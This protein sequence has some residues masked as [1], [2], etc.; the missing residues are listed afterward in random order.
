MRC[1]KITSY[2]I[3][4][5]R[6]TSRQIALWGGAIACATLALPMATPAPAYAATELAYTDTNF[7]GAKLGKVFVNPSAFSYNNAII[8]YG[9]GWSHWTESGAGTAVSSDWTGEYIG[10]PG[11]SSQQSIVDP[12]TITWK[13]AGYT[14]SGQSVGIR[15]TIRSIWVSSYDPEDEKHW[16]GTNA[17]WDGVLFWWTGDGLPYFVSCTT[18]KSLD[19]LIEVIDANGNRMDMP[20][21]WS[22]LDLD[23]NDAGL[24]DTPESP[25]YSGGYCNKAFGD[26]TNHIYAEGVVIDSGVTHTYLT[27]PTFINQQVINDSGALWF[28]GTRESKSDGIQDRQAGFALYAPHG[29]ID[30]DWRG[31]DC[32][33]GMFGG[34]YGGAIPEFDKPVKST[35]NDIVYEGD[36]VTYNIDQMLPVVPD[37][38][39]AHSIT[40]TDT[41]NSAL[42]PTD[43]RVYK[44]STDVT[45]NWNISI[46]GQSVTATAKNTGHSSSTAAQGQHRFVVTAKVKTGVN[47]SALT[48]SGDYYII[49]NKA[50]VTLKPTST[51]TLTQETNTVN[52][53]IKGSAISI[54]KRADAFEY[55]PDGTITY[56]L[57]VSNIEPSSRAYNVRVADNSLPA[58]FKIHSVNISSPSSVA[59]HQ[60]LGSGFNATIPAIEYGKPVTITVKV[61]ANNDANGKIFLNTASST[62][63]NPKPGA[64]QTV[65]DSDHVWINRAKL[66]LSKTPDNREVHVGETVKYTVHLRN[67]NKGTVGRN[68]ELADELPDTMKLNKSSIKIS[69]IP[70]KVSVPVDGNHK[71]ETYQDF[72]NPYV[73]NTDATNGFSISFPL[74]DDTPDVVVEYTAEAL[75][76]GNGMTVYNRATANGDNIETPPP[77][78]EEKVFINSP[79]VD[80]DKAADAFEYSPGEIITYTV[81]VR[82]AVEGA[83]AKQVV[84]RDDLPSTVSLI[85][86]SVEVFSPT[87]A[88]PVVECRPPHNITKTEGVQ[89]EPARVATK[90]NIIQITVP[91]L[92]SGE[93][94]TV[95]YKARANDDSAGKRPVNTATVAFANPHPD[96]AIDYPKRALDD[97]WIN[98]AR[99]K[100]T[101]CADK[102]EY[103]IGETAHFTIGLHNAVSAQGTIAKNV[104]LTDTQ[105]PDD[106]KIDMDSI[107]VSGIPSPIH[108]P[109]DG[110]G[111]PQDETRD[112]KWELV[113]NEGGNGF[114]LTI[115][116]FPDNATATITYDA[117]AVKEINGLDG[118]NSASVEDDN[119]NDPGDE[120]KTH[121]WVNDAMLKLVKS[122]D[123]FEHKVGDT[124]EY[125][126]SLSNAAA[127]TI[128]KNVIIEDISLP[129]G[130]RLIENSVKVSG[131][132]EKV[133]Y[134]VAANENATEH[135]TEVRDNPV[136]VA[137]KGNGFTVS[138]PYLPSGDAVSI[139][140]QAVMEEAVNGTVVKNTATATCDNLVPG[141]DPKD[142]CDNEIVYVN[143]S[144]LAVQKDTS[145]PELH[146]G[147]EASYTIK[148]SNIAHGTIAGVPVSLIDDMPEGLEIVENS[149][150]VSGVPDK[151]DYPIKDAEKT[152]TA[153]EVRNNKY[154]V[155]VAENKRSFTIDID[156]VPG[157]TEIV[158]EYR[159]RA[160]DIAN[161]KH[162]DN[163]VCVE[164]PNNP[165][166]KPTDKTTVFV[167]SPEINIAKHADAHEY[168]VG[169]EITYILDISSV[170]EGTIARD[171]VTEDLLPE[172]FELVSGTVGVSALPAGSAAARIEE[173][174]DGLQG[175]RVVIPEMTYGNATITYKVRAVA[176]AEGVRYINH[177]HLT[178]DNIPPYDTDKYPKEAIDDIWVN[179]AKTKTTKSADKF[180]YEIGETAHFTIGL[181]N[182]SAEGAIAKNVVLTDIQLPE[183]FKIDMNSI[184]V[185]G[186]PDTVS[187]PIDGA[188]VLREEMRENAW[189]VVPHESGAGFDLRIKYLPQGSLVS[190][191]YDAVAVRE[192]NGLDALDKVSAKSDNPNDPGDSS[193]VHVWVNT[194]ELVLDKVVDK[195]EHQVGEEV[196]YT[197][198]LSNV[199][200]GTV[201]KNI[202]VADVSLPTYLEL[203]RNSVEVAGVPEKV[204]YPE[205]DENNQRV[206]K[207]YPNS[208][209]VFYEGDEGF[210]TAIA[211]ASYSNHKYAYSPLVA[212]GNVNADEGKENADKNDQA[213][214]VAGN[215]F[216]VK[217]DYLP[218]GVPIEIT[219]RAHVKEEANGHDIENF[220]S[221]D[222][223]NSLK[224]VET[225]DEPNPEDPN[226][227]DPSIPGKPGTTTSPVHDTEL[228]HI[229]T[230]ALEISKASDE[231][232]MRTGDTAHY[233]LRVKNTASGTLARNIVIKDGFAPYAGVEFKNISVV[234]MAKDG[235][236]ARAEKIDAPITKTEN[237]GIKIETGVNLIADGFLTEVYNREEKITERFN[238]E[239]C[240][241]YSEIV[242]EYD[243]VATQDM[244]ASHF[245][246]IAT[247]SA[248]NSTPVRDME[249]LDIATIKHG[250]QLTTYKSAS[251]ASGTLIKQGD[252]ITYTLAVKN[253]GKDAVPFAHIRDYLPD[254]VSFVSVADAGVY[255]GSAA[256]QA[257][258]NAKIS[259]DS[260]CGYVEWVLQDIAPNTEK[261]ISYKVK[262]NVLDS[263]DAT[264]PLYIRN[265]A[266]YEGTSDNPGAPGN[267]PAERI[268]ILESNEV[269]HYTDPD[270]PAPAIID[271]EKFSVPAPGS[272]VHNTDEITY[273]LVIRNNGAQAGKHILVR[274]YIDEKLIVKEESIV[275]GAYD[276]A[277][278]K[279][280]W[281]IE[282]L[283]AGEETEVSFTA[284][285]QNT[286]PD[287]IIVNQALFENEWYDAGEGDPENSTNIIEH[288]SDGDYM[289]A[290]ELIE[291][292]ETGQLLTVPVLLALIGAAAGS[293]LFYRRRIRS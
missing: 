143:T 285:V 290:D 188:G 32:A 38:N 100:V 79:E 142:L 134:K 28:Y 236:N 216:I 243:I 252:E 263:E 149:I 196:R 209:A 31:T 256:E 61:S 185:S 155:S 248:G 148:L 222:C 70:E 254:G 102:Y 119:P 171:I 108:H 239:G 249:S 281:I 191:E 151:I 27:N 83:V 226:P 11:I 12:L 85:E 166:E 90:N 250:Y 287:D 162:L 116:Y 98:D 206:D 253:T 238:S 268:P 93:D 265:V 214:S 240:E 204:I 228:V 87:G 94:V 182:V 203:V 51:S 132:P 237:G 57:T 16:W 215:G 60:I 283:A 212:A 224:E 201:G 42:T 2:I 221:A 152:G 69:G 14:S 284:V 217:C 242:V 247:A 219:Y 109:I 128:A 163:Q 123:E 136:N 124:V 54:Q 173:M 92:G 49:P 198:R 91:F 223:D 170:F 56:N 96:S 189:E 157:D 115:P 133:D 202:Y 75:A 34:F 234:G 64:A 187:Y 227:D 259:A 274:D 266:L 50:I 3:G 88:I 127:G 220:A 273:T 175:F 10:R 68:I 76:S 121:I 199:A 20:F 178:F 145:T 144:H 105:L 19:F 81:H 194:A 146:V 44:G 113:P 77:S 53:R 184:K 261:K 139:S 103:R 17:G 72:D 288:I 213:L 47:Y 179:D 110:S 15:L 18:S 180:E 257:V 153:T 255:V 129:A 208:Y 167:N 107:K 6:K 117:V 45:S 158:I 192:I 126:L 59:T 160:L 74:L 7:S 67:I 205:R 176:G 260:G 232:F 130:A 246:N 33:T 36:T 106:F 13:N 190:I 82:Q 164:N 73:L 276:D 225:P 80:I 193:E 111:I 30:G 95:V 251:P 101:K 177:A 186:V 141:Q 270:Y 131:V 104:V 52:V 210:D 89:Y 207:E 147:Q 271:V 4:K 291:I 277:A 181:S 262:V 43:I 122:T 40:F 62:F 97:V 292:P 55:L 293:A 48:K 244:L 112:N 5:F 272:R 195:E 289:V 183:D 86:G 58:S 282:E 37:A 8:N 165:D 21:Q 63:S 264:L 218:A 172:H 197:L 279:V 229:N 278:R 35:P 137:Y 135:T 230:P 120:T 29:Y 78:V 41:L 169:D 286:I 150:T 138:F 25:A 168:N 161:G 39:K 26:W 24:A 233:T 114:T 280:D 46:S 241:K 159:A 156:Y 211:E 23:T 71:D 174:P 118:L 269:I 200:A 99:M 66:A 235:D 231:H 9:S 140:Y 65:Q 258:D 275:G 245:D 84:I 22:F 1:S 125:H 154:V 267:I